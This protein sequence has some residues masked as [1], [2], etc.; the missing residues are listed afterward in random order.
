M[1]Y[2]RHA[3]LALFFGFF[4]F[5]P[6][7]GGGGG[8]SGSGVTRGVSTAPEGEGLLNVVATTSI[9]G[10]VVSQIGGDAIELHVLI[11]RGQDPHSFEPTPKT[12]AA[13]ESAEIIFTNGFG[14]EESLLDDIEAAAGGEVI[15]ASRNIDPLSF[16]E[17]GDHPENGNAED[18]DEEEDHGEEHHDHGDVDPHV[19]FDPTNV[20]AWVDAIE[21][22]LEEADPQNAGVY[23]MRAAAYMAK[24]KELDTTIREQAASLP[25]AK[26]KLVTDHDVFSYFA[27]EYGFE[28]IGAIIPTMSGG[29]EVSARHL[30]GLVD[31]LRRENI[32]TIF[33]GATAGRSVRS[34]ANSLAAELD[35]DIQIVSILTGSLTKPGGAGDTY[36]DYMEYNIEKIFAALAAEL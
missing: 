12:L 19:W 4:I 9:L 15:A 26:R 8:E 24:L 10:D 17:D 21:K 31:L 1:T 7:F 6:L 3:L 13:I 14:L 2:C 30:A 29:A 18:E 27:E 25:D 20:M 28:I 5:T 35:R 34:L 32:G 23:E 11:G 36:I 16:D 22:V 33:I